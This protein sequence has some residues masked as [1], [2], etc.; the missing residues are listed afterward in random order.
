MPF[1]FVIFILSETC[2]F[3]RYWS[4]SAN[5][6]V[7]GCLVRRQLVLHLRFAASDQHQPL[8]VQ[9]RE[10]TSLCTFVLHVMSDR[11]NRFRSNLTFLFNP[12]VINQVLILSIYHFIEVRNTEGFFAKMIHHCNKFNQ[13]FVYRKG[14]ALDR[15]SRGPEKHHPQKWPAAKHP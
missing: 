15:P 13:S 3:K 11:N 9:V 2:V 14:N 10:L 8:E 4:F 6:A 5:R 12:T 7:P 1:K